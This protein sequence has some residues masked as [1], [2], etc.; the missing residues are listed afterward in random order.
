MYAAF[1]NMSIRLVSITISDE[2]GLQRFTCRGIID[3]IG[4]CC[5][6]YILVRGVSDSQFAFFKR[7][8]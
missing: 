1:R 5:V 6:S 2:P 8:S 3:I 7:V 4:M